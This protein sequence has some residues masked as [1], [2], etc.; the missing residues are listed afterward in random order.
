MIMQKHYSRRNVVEL[1]FAFKYLSKI[2]LFICIYDSV[3]RAT[4]ID[5]KLSTFVH[6]KDIHPINKTLCH[7]HIICH[8]SKIEML[9]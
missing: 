2:I 4:M 9:F 3:I 7:I 8:F 1:S 5:H 6:L